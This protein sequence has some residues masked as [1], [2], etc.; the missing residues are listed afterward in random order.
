MNI[1]SNTNDYI[2]DRDIA[3]MAEEGYWWHPDPPTAADTENDIRDKMTVIQMLI[4]ANSR[5]ANGH[6][7]KGESNEH[8]ST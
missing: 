4:D 5:L 3:I 6:Y 7:F 1:I 8:P 2:T